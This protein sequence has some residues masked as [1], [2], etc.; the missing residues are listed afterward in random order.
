MPT[1][2]TSYITASMLR[3]FNALTISVN[4]ITHLSKT[5]AAAQN[6]CVGLTAQK[7]EGAQQLQ[8]VRTQDL[9]AKSFHFFSLSI[10]FSP[11]CLTYLI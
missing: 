6:L 11:Y 8:E 4:I 2:G 5:L 7:A 3:N 10:Y 9:K 1:E